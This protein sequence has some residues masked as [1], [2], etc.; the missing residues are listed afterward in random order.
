MSRLRSKGHQ[1]YLVGGAVRDLLLGGH[2]KDFDIATDATPEAF[3]RCSATPA[4]LAAAFVSFTCASA[5]RLSKSPP[6]AATTTAATRTTGARRQPLPPI[7]QR[8]AAARQC[9]RHP[10]RGCGAPRPDGERPVLR[11]RQVRSI[12]SCTRLAG[13]ATRNICVIGDPAVRFREDPVRMLRVLRFA[14][15]LD[16]SIDPDTAKAIPGCAAPA[17]GNSRSAPV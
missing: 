2:P 16:F 1:A 6:F 8:A 14:A 10:G 4:S 15:K 17:G 12:R 9:L 3:T 5:A 7:C 13:P 11:L